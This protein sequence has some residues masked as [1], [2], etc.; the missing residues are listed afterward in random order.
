[1]RQHVAVAVAIEGDDII[2][3]LIGDDDA[4]GMAA[5]IA[6]KALQPFGD[7][8]HL[9]DDR[10]IVVQI[11]HLR[12]HLHRL[13]DGHAGSWGDELRELVDL[14][15]RHAHHTA[16]ILAGGF[17]SERTEGD[18]LGDVA[19]F[20]ADVFDD[21]LPPV[22]ADVDVDIRHLIAAWVHEPLEEQVVF[23]RVDIAQAEQVTDHRP[24]A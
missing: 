12:D 23:N 3:R 11:V 19:I 18:D 6:A 4:G 21:L 5:G 14:A 9:L 2:E 7:V 8:D 1:M 15:E 20:V 10:R 17:R 16:H 24:D 13:V 22:L